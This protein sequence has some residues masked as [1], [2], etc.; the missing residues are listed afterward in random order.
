[1]QTPEEVLKTVFPIDVPDTSVVHDELP[2]HEG[3]QVVEDHAETTASGPVW[4][5]PNKYKQDLHYFED[6]QFLYIAK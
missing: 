6:G 3:D 2:P 5:D 4:T 1:M